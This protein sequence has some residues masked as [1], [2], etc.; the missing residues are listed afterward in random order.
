VREEGRR[1]DEKERR[2]QEVGRGSDNKE[3]GRLQQRN[4]WS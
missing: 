4:M 2:R 3:K 1:M